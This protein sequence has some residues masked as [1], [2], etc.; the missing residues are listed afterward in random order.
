MKTYIYVHIFSGVI[1][2]CYLDCFNYIHASM[3]FAI[4]IYSSKHPC[5]HIRVQ[6]ESP[7]INQQLHARS[8]LTPN[9]SLA[10]LF[11]QTINGPNT[12]INKLQ[13]FQS[14][15]LHGSILVAWAWSLH[16]FLCLTK[17]H[18]PHYLE[19]K[20]T[21]VNFITITTHPLFFRVWSTS[22]F[23]SLDKSTLLEFHT[24]GYI[25]NAFCSQKKLAIILDPQYVKV[26]MFDILHLLPSN[27]LNLFF[28]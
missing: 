21:I 26:N 1:A 7:T 10:S 5:I 11:D 17:P 22:S 20:S 23:G 9:S 16:G 4:A 24:Y 2:H 14:I 12:T 25:P 6:K 3:L 18:S 19:N 8:H 15:E 27:W 28:F 13:L